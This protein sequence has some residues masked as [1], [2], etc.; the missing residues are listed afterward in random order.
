MQTVRTSSVTRR[1]NSNSMVIETK[2][3]WTAGKT[4]SA[5]QVEFNYKLNPL[6]DATWARLYPDHPDSAEMIRLMDTCGMDDFEFSSILVKNNEGPLLLLP[7]FTT[8]Y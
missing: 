1:G 4:D 7:L 6:D 3:P 2:K 5:V 8:H